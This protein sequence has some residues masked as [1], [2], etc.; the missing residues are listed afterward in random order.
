MHL[1]TTAISLRL[2]LPAVIIER[3]DH[4]ARKVLKRAHEFEADLEPVSGGAT[5]V[6]VRERG[7]AGT[8]GEEAGGAAA[9]G[10]GAATPWYRARGVSYRPG[11]WCYLS[12]VG[13]PGTN[14]YQARSGAYAPKRG[15]P[16]VPPR[17]VLPP[18]AALAP[19]HHP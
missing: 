14:I 15:S 8:T 10:S 19:T 13:V 3:V 12:V 16:R 18:A 17:V 2:L 4:I 7:V 6:V 1:H 5:R 11:Q 9:A